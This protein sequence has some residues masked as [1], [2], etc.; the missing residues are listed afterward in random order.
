MI[1]RRSIAMLTLSSMPALVLAQQAPVAQAFRDK[2]KQLGR[3]L[4]DAAAVMP[5]DKYDY[6]PT[7]AQMTFGDIVVHVAQV[8]DFFCGA[9][10]GV[11]APTRSEIAPTDSKD[12][13]VARLRETFQFCDQVLATLDDSKLTEQLPMTSWT[14][15]RT[16]SGGATLPRIAVQF[17]TVENWAGHLA[18]MAN[19]LRLNNILLAGA[20]K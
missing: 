12:A 2:A 14:M 18:R 6:K 15:T 16:M 1:C 5:S 11:K 4:M 7:P 13:L 19:Y 10:G 17:T 3:N 9:I 8:N 20:K